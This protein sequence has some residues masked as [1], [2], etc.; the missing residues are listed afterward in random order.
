MT[1]EQVKQEMEALLKAFQP[2]LKRRPAQAAIYRVW[3]R[4]WEAYGSDLLPCYD[5]PGLPPDNLMLEALFGRL[6]RHQR[7]VSGRKA[8]RA[9]RDF[10]Q[11]QVL[12]LSESEEELL[13]Q[14]RQVSLEEYREH[15]RRLE[16]AEAPRRLLHCL[17][18]DPLGTMRRLVA[19]HAVRRAELASVTSRS[20]PQGDD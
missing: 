9:L 16:E 13:E 18:R 10:G 19:Q 2:D 5:I 14:L 8:T 1:G 3:H 11:Y 17:H 20:P 7:R 12:F 15:R 4:T 6:R